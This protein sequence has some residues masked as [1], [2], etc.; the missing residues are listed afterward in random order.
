MEHNKGDFVAPN[1]QSEP[2]R[3]RRQALARGIFFFFAT[4]VAWTGRTTRLNK[5][6][7]TNDSGSP[8]YYRHVRTHKKRHEKQRP[9]ITSTGERDDL[10]EQLPE[11]S[12][13]T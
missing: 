4:G 7:R 2:S 9:Y 8:Q 12:T 10:S 5:W 1:I 3:Q 13:K 11:P 6:R